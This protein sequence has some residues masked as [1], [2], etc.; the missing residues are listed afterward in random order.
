MDKR[1]KHGLTKTK[2]HNIW[3]HMRRRCNNPKTHCYHRYGGRGITICDRWNNSF[4]NFY[5]DMGKSPEGTSIER[6]DNNSGYFKENCKWATKTEQSN[7]R[8]TTHLETYKGETMP[9]KMLCKQFNVDYRRVWL[10]IKRGWSISNAIEQPAKI[11]AVNTRRW[12][13]KVA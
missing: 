8:R 11:I 6:I 5:E 10:R 4:A 3:C 12:P 1:F 7:N 9:L 2:E 13:K